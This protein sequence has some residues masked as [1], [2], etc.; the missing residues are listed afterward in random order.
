MRSMLFDFDGRAP[1]ACPRLR[2]WWA[3][4]DVG[5]SPAGRLTRRHRHLHVWQR[6]LT[7]VFDDSTHVRQ[8]PPYF[9]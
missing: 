9:G 5:G 1:L 4:Q 8:E 6:L 2:R 3:C 7:P